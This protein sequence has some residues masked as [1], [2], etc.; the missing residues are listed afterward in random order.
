MYL[1]SISVPDSVKIIHTENSTFDVGSSR[2]KLLNGDMKF[3]FSDWTEECL[4]KVSKN[5]I[6]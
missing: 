1:F 2:Y 4:G 3:N 6:T 5:I